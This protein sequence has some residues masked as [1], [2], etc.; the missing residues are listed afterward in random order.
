MSIHIN[1]LSFSVKILPHSENELQVERLG[2]YYLNTKQTLSINDGCKIKFT[3]SGYLTLFLS[4]HIKLYMNNF[5]VIKKNILDIC[6]LL[7][8]DIFTNIELDLWYF[9]TSSCLKH[10]LKFKDIFYSDSCAK[11]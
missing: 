9:H 2:S 10:K 4:S 6:N 3:R 11:T 5:D 7:S 1:C 8:E